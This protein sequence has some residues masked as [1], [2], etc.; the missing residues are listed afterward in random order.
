MQTRRGAEQ[1]ERNIRNALADGTYGKQEVKSIP[2]LA[3]FKN[4]FIEEYCEANKHKPSGIDSKKSA[5]KNYLEPLFATKSLDTFTPA[6]EDKM[7]KSSSTSRPPPTT[8][9]RVA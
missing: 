4:R 3:E 5:F 9:R 7:K 1:H 6:D 8:T 2:T